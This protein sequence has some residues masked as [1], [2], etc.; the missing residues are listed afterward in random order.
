[1]NTDTATTIAAPEVRLVALSRLEASKLNPRTT[2]PKDYIGELTASVKAEGILT[3]L[4][5]RPAACKGIV[6]AKELP[7]YDAATDTGKL[8]IVSGECRFRAASAAQL[9]DVPVIIRVL[10]DPQLVVLNLIEQMQRNQLTPLEEG[11][12]FERMLGYK[13]EAGNPLHTAVSLAEEVGKEKWYVY[14]RLKLLDLTKTGKAALS[15]GR[16]VMRVAFALARIPDE[17]ERET[18]TKE[19]LRGRQ[20]EPMTVRD[21]LEFIKENHMRALAGSPFDQKD[22]SLVT[23][24]GSCEKCP[25]RTGNNPDAFGDVK[26]GDICTRPACYREKL[27]AHHARAAAKAE[28]EGKRVL[29][30]AESQQVFPP[31]LAVGSIGYNCSLVALDQKPEPHL[32]KS[33]V[34]NVPTWGELVDTIAKAPVK[35]RSKEKDGTTA[36]TEMP[37]GGR[38]QVFL[39]TDQRGQLVE[40]V[41]REVVMAAAEK[42]G[43][44]IFRGKNEPRSPADAAFKKR[45]REEAEEAKLRSLVAI[46]ALTEFRTAL[47]KRM[48]PSPLWEALLENGL[49]VLGGEGAMFLCKWQKLPN[50]AAFGWYLIITRWWRKLPPTEQQALVPLLLL[51]EKMR[52]DGI[53]AKGVEEL[54]AWLKVDLKALD[55]RVRAEAKKPKTKAGKKPS[56]PK[57]ETTIKT[58]GEKASAS[59]GGAAARA[60]AAVK[61][62]IKPAKKG[63]AK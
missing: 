3:P 22:E 12:S 15:D 38:P 56:K 59:K 4:L 10:T 55:K 31:H 27:Q 60:I 49:E 36:E 25:F 35:V 6:H 14:E 9:A 17:K 21:A 53:K 16:L 58:K 1:M 51:A 28:A 41:E 62:S 63:G 45:Q 20:G 30:I 34:K 13:D 40:M 61:G 18:A 11:A 44:P 29:T 37:L 32:L 24:A 50:D 33:V 42:A 39:A 48:E 46:A 19:I 2:F 52:W 43:E 5:V 23:K 57:P 26:R 7:A 8:E 54:A 47:L